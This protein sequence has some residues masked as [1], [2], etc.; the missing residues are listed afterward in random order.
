M[1]TIGIKKMNKKRILYML[2]FFAFMII[3]WTRGSQ[4]GVVW[5]WTVNM[6]GVVMAV[7][8]LSAGKIREFKR[9]IY[10]LYSVLCIV[11]LPLSYMWWNV[12]QAAI[13]RD[14]LLS[15]VLNVWVLGV[16]VIKMLLDV[17]IYR[18]KKLHFSKIEMIGAIMLLWMFLSKNEDVWPLWYL[19]MFGLLYHTEYTI[20]DREQMKQ[21]LLDGIILSFFVLQGA[22]FVF[23]PFD[24]AS[25]RYCGIYGNAN[26]NALFYSIVFV[27]FLLKLH[28]VRKNKD[29]KWKEILCFLFA[30]AM[31]GFILMTISKTAGIAMVAGYIIFVVLA[32]LKQ[33]RMKAGKVVARIIL[34]FIL[35]L[36][37]L[38]IDYC[39]VRYI[40]PIFHHPIWFD[41][42]Y[43]EEKV[44]S[45]D[46]W[47]SDKYVSFSEVLNGIS[48]RIGPYLELLGEKLTVQAAELP[49]EDATTQIQT[50]TA[51]ETVAIASTEDNSIDED[52]ETEE[53]DHRFDSSRGRL[54]IWQYYL[55]Q[56]NL[57]GHSNQ[58]GHGDTLGWYVWHAQNMF[59]QFWYYYGIPAAI[60]FAIY[61]IMVLKKA[62]QKAWKEDDTEA[63]MVLLYF[64]L[65]AIYGLFE[66]TWYPGQ[67]ILLLSFFVPFFLQKKDDA[68]I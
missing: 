29:K 20:E 57:V 46:P 35:I 48:S 8:L 67:M 54:I 60:L 9:P 59:I 30:G 43:S 23:R 24:D 21:G 17:V 7:I 4:I 45:W 19:I 40:P 66:A 47:N 55:Q 65:F 25:S 12:H 16:F 28:L 51:G 6:T 61:V 1:Q 22:A 58:E 44:H 14:R 27:A 11:A 56:G 41:G 2:C 39:A 53:V 38:P 18:T 33:L 32:D 5:A 68:I 31:S 15:A 63:L 64:M 36:V 34:M 42:E 13:Y 50:E 37:T 49:S 3:D 52:A 26:M 62:F 10:L